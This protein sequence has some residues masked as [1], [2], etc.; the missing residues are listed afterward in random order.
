MMHSDERFYPNKIK[1]HQLENIS[2][3][4][5]HYSLESVDENIRVLFQEAFNVYKDQYFGL[6][7]YCTVTVNKDQEEERRK[8]SD[9]P[10]DLNDNT[11]DPT[12]KDE[13]VASKYSIL[14]LIKNVECKELVWDSAHHCKIQY[15]SHNCEFNYKLTSYTIVTDSATIVE[16][17]E[18][19]KRQT[20]NP[21]VQFNSHKRIEFTN[22]AKGIADHVIN[23]GKAIEQIDGAFRQSLFDIFWARLNSQA[24]FLQPNDSI[25]PNS[26]MIDLRQNIMKQMLRMTARN[27]TFNEQL[28]ETNREK[29]QLEESDMQKVEQNLQNPEQNC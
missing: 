28:N 12:Y 19:E 8:E 24:S 10:S 29:S 6:P 3:F 26:E 1:N 11:N 16:E 20:A 9:Q 4:P 23:L 5:T 27:S 21:I 22:E 14:V 13:F 2:S 17:E 7:S 15:S 25:G 18:T